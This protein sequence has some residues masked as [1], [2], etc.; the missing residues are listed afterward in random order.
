M[1]EYT[2]LDRA[3]AA[4]ELY[5]TEEHNYR[6]DYGET[7]V[8]KVTRPPHLLRLVAA[9]PR[10]VHERKM[11]YAATA[12]VGEYRIAVRTTRVWGERKEPLVPGSYALVNRPCLVDRYTP[13]MVAK[14]AEE[15][16]GLYWA[17]AADYG[18]TPVE[19]A[20]YRDIVARIAQINENCGPRCDPGSCREVRYLALLL[21]R[22]DA[23]DARILK[24]HRTWLRRRHALAAFGRV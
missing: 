22:K 11:R 3:L 13:V 7:V 2:E 15:E 20:E 19:I 16:E 8:V 14:G 24:Y 6:N 4:G 5:T 21:A 9:L 23:L 18:I 17:D 10:L 1:T 12:A